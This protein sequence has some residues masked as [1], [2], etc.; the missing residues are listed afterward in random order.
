MTT[1]AIEC[2]HC[3]EFLPFEI[4]ETQGKFGGERYINT[5]AI[6]PKCGTYHTHSSHWKG[7][8]H[9]V[10]G[11]CSICGKGAAYNTP[12]LR[13]DN[14]QIVCNNCASRNYPKDI[15][16]IGIDQH[17]KENGDYKLEEKYYL[18]GNVI[19][20]KGDK[21]ES[22][23]THGGSRAFQLREE[24]EGM[25]LLE[26]FDLMQTVVGDDPPRFRCS[27]CV[28]D[29]MGEPAG[30]PLFAGVNCK[31]CWEKHQ[32]HLNQQRKTGQV[33]RM[34]GQPWGNCCC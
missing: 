28:M 8:G 16:L 17:L 10:L 6:C 23:W 13:S 30:Y 31:G 22:M 27:G 1:E 15:V 5:K 12:A 25:G 4:V 34:C 21:P 24:E 7:T 14:G 33:C 19:W 11:K 18:N 2:P 32:E 20:W 9:W 26:I 29:Y 3:Q